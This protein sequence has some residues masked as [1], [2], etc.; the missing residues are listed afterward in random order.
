MVLKRN[1]EKRELKPPIAP[2]Q[3]TNYSLSIFRSEADNL[4]FYIGSTDWCKHQFHLIPNTEHRATQYVVGPTPKANF[5]LQTHWCF[6]T[7]PSPVDKQTEVYNQLQQKV[8]LALKDKCGD[9]L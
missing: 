9:I 4:H 7:V 1:Q 3:L 6:L 8:A 5:T 2:P